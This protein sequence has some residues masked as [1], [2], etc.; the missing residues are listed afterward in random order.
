MD[1]GFVFII[2]D[3]F[4][5]EDVVDWIGQEPCCTRAELWAAMTKWVEWAELA[6]E[7]RCRSGE[8]WSETVAAET[9]RDEERAT[10]RG[11][12]GMETE[13]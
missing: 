12:L 11:L 3:R 4:D 8:F 2:G 13:S 1:E 5:A 10:V 6:V 7:H 9:E